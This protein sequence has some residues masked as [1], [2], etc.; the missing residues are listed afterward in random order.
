M[1]VRPDNK[2]DERRSISANATVGRTGRTTTSYND[3]DARKCEMGWKWDGSL[4]WEDSLF[5]GTIQQRGNVAGG[6]V[7][8]ILCLGDREALEELFK[9]GEGFGSLF[10]RDGRDL[11]HN[12]DSGHVGKSFREVEIERVLLGWWREA[13]V[14]N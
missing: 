14:C 11:I 5:D 2:S 9:D 10:C 1:N 12:I 8:F 7:G 4:C 13:D 3:Q 6:C